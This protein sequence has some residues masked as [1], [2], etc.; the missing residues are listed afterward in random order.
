MLAHNLAE[1][2]PEPD[3][4]RYPEYE[5]K[6]P[7]YRA[8]LEARYPQVCRDCEPRVR[9]RLKLTGYAAKTDHLR[10][11]AETTRRTHH[12]E[13]RSNSLR[14]LFV[15]GGLFWGLAQLGQIVWHAAELGSLI[16][17]DEPWLSER[18]KFLLRTIHEI[19]GQKDLE[20]AGENDWSFGKIP[21]VLSVCCLWWNPALLR[22]S[23]WQTPG[24]G[25]FYKLQVLLNVARFLVWRFLGTDLSRDLEPT[26]LR[27]VHAT[28]MVFN[29]F[30]CSI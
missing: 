7:Q 21:L 16:P 3:D 28:A 23:W 19:A 13:D 27:A 18:A 9:E 12:A 2:L 8:S 5:R 26:H 17:G 24:I 10:R 29:I 22:K 11:L 14:I 25:E 30:V 20:F 1:Y 6:L 15:L 4:L